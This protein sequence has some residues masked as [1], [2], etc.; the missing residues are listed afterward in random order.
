MMK[1]EI[2]S[3][4]NIFKCIRM[5]YLRMI[6]NKIQISKT[7]CINYSNIHTVQIKKKD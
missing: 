1:I 2:K 3:Q 7:K 5:V 4:D 6:L